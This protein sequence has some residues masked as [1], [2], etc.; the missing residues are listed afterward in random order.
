MYPTGLLWISERPSEGKYVAWL[1]ADISVF[2]RAEGLQDN[3]NG[4]NQL[5]F[6]SKDDKLP[7]VESRLSRPNWSCLDISIM[8]VS[9]IAI[10]MR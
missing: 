10:A 3:V 9:V 8:A 1:V 5:F 7:L 4:T 2:L 6:W